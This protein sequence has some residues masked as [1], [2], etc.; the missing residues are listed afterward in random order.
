[1]EVRDK[2]AR[3]V[4]VR[5]TTPL[6]RSLVLAAAGTLVLAVVAA[7]LRPGQAP[8]PTRTPFSRSAFSEPGS[9][10]TRP[11]Q[12]P[13]PSAL[14]AL[15]AFGAPVPV[16]VLLVRASGLD[17]LDLTTGALRPLA[18]VN[19][20]TR[21]LPLPDGRFVCVCVDVT[22]SGDE[23]RDAVSIQ[24]IGR[25]GKRALAMRVY[26]L[27]GTRDPRIT[28]DEEGPSVQISAALTLDGRFVLVG[29]SVR[30]PPEWMVGLDVVEVAS[31]RLVRSFDLGRSPSNRSDEFASPSPRASTGPNPAATPRIVGGVYAWPPTIA[32]APD[33]KNVLLSLD[34]VRGNTVTSRRSF[35]ASFGNTGL[36][37]LRPFPLAEAGAPDCWAW[38]F[39]DGRTLIRLC[40]P[41]SVSSGWILERLR[42]DGTSDLSIRLDAGADS[43][44]SFAWGRILDSNGRLWL[45]DPFTWWIARVDLAS[46]TVESR[47]LPRPTAVG[48]GNGLTALLRGLAAFV[49]PSVTAKVLI[50]PALAISPDGARL[51]ALAAASSSPE[52]MAGSSGIVVIDAATLALVDRWEPVADFASIRA[53]ADGRF[54][55]GAGL[56]RVNAAGDSASWDASVTAYD[57]QTGQVRLIAG[58][59]GSDWLFFPATDDPWWSFSG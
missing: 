19:W 8:G 9:T 54:V 28:P 4:R 20:P 46:G 18:S 1:M 33:G 25:D 53:S 47:R 29:R 12:G 44:A 14:P 24:T 22:S 38:A 31:G 16:D 59:L 35:L 10:H 48:P 5:I 27:V 37:E 50:E 2:A 42:I 17:L 51:Y 45:W 32:L 43:L 30:Q 15:Q 21:V 36:V 11:S 52:A 6:G 56:P 41:P 55:Y 58:H 49:A 40:P 39:A 34:E 23:E 3:P 13:T 26:E 57:A 7:A